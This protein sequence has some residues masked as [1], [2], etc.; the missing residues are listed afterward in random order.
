MKKRTVKLFGIIHVGSAFMSLHIVS[1][2]AVDQIEI[3]ERITREVS[4]GEE[5][6]QTKRLSFESLNEMCD[7]LKGFKRLLKEYGVRDYHVFGTTAIREAVNRINIVDQVHIK[8]GFEV[9]VIDMPKEIYYKY[10]ALYR[11]LQENRVDFGDDA[12]LFMD[13]TS[14]GLAVTVWKSGELLFQQNV[15]IGA[16]RVLEN[17]SRNQRDSLAFPTAL[18]AYV[19]GILSPLWFMIEKFNIRYFVLSGAEARLIAQMMG[20]GTI[21]NNM[22]EI[23]P[24]R[25]DAFFASF[26]GVSATKL[27]KRYHV[28]ENRA[29]V[30]IPTLLLYEEVLHMVNVDSIIVMSTSFL[31]GVTMYYGAEKDNDPYLQVQREQN[32][33]LARNIGKK[34]QYNEK[35]ARKLET[36]SLV[37][38]E[39]MKKIHGLTL[40][41]SYLLR[42]AAILHEIGKFVNL[43]NHNQYSYELIM[44]TD[45][46]G[47]SEEE[48]QIV[49]NIAYYHYK[50]TPSDDDDDFR[51]LAEGQKRSI[52]K[53]VAIFRL[54]RAL[55]QGHDE[56]I[57]SIGATMKKNALE[58]VYK[59]N[60][61]ISLERWTFAKEASYF[62]EVF[63]VKP[64]L[65]KK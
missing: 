65:I 18:R 3:I 17:F 38:F 37:L 19:H 52:Y 48:K 25:L 5:V 46:F 30:L 24:K 9:D 47:L 60:A 13:I 8:T 61:D 2:E 16:I 41:S 39:S 28:S 57:I 11:H 58:I 23:K 49:A 43:R 32:I 42:M 31:D 50:G 21:V 6:F 7:I 56:K 15:H 55:D 27:M 53:L 35:H 14:G 1:Y 51:K 34:Y 54:A 29:D 26:G 20:V 64:I 45:I 33:S 63:G 62:Q 22:M 12:V 40:R 59:A 44:G 36:F 4:Y 10:F